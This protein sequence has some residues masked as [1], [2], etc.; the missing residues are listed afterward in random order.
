MRDL[1]TVGMESTE[2]NQCMRPLDKVRTAA[3]RR[4]AGLD[5]EAITPPATLSGIRANALAGAA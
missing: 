1:R 3:E 5:P 4:P 2:G